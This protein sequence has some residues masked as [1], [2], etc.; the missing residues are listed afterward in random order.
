MD[1][2]GFTSSTSCLPCESLV[3]EG[4]APS[5]IAQTSGPGGFGIAID[6]YSREACQRGARKVRTISMGTHMWVLF[7]T[8]VNDH[9][10]QDATKILG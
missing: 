5:F 7:M 3:Q 2:P 4:I 9:L 8:A 1:A 10:L 6:C